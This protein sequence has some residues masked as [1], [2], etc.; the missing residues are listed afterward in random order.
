MIAEPTPEA[1]LFVLGIFGVGDGLP[2]VLAL[3]LWGMPLVQATATSLVGV[4]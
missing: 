2:I 1:L 4:F 3:T